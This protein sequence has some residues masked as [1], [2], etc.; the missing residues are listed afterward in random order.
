MQQYFAEDVDLIDKPQEITFKD[1][2]LTL[3]FKTNSGLF[4]KD[5]IDSQ[6]L[7]LVE[8]IE[9]KQYQNI[10]DLGCGY[11]FI[12]IYLAK[13]YDVKITFVDITSRACEYT[14]INCES[15]NINNYQIIKADGLNLE[16]KFDLIVLNP[17][18]HVGKEKLYQLYQQAIDHLTENGSF[19]LVIHKKHGAKS[20]IEYL[21]TIALVNI[22]S[23]KKALYIIKIERM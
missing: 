18:I 1:N 11:G 22:V 20:T 21:E 12:G 4:S 3:K 16:Q 14:K 15:N 23:K 5:E 10:L 17:P 19:Y 6:S 2:N 8:N 13:R 9:A 7:K